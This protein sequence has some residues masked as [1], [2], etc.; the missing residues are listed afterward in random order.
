[1]WLLCVAPKTLR[2]LA[3]AGFV[4]GSVVVLDASNVTPRL[5]A[6]PGELATGGVAIAGS[7][8]FVGADDRLKVF[9]VADP[10][11]PVLMGE[12]ASL[13]ADVRAM[14]ASG[15]VVG[16]VL[17]GGGLRLVDAADPKQPIVVASAPAAD[18]TRGVAM[19]GSFVLLP[20]ASV[21]RILAAAT[22]AS[23]R[24]VAV[25][26]PPGEVL[27]VSVAERIAYVVTSENALRTLDLADPSR[28][29]ELG[30]AYMRGAGY[31]L[32]PAIVDGFA[33]TTLV[34]GRYTAAVAF[35]V[36]DPARVVLRSSIP[37]SL[38]G[39]A[40]FATDR[41]LL[42]AANRSA[43]NGGSI[44]IVAPDNAGGASATGSLRTRWAPVEVAAQAGFAYVLGADRYLRAL[45]ISDPSRPRMVSTVGLTPIGS[46]PTLR[47]DE[48]YFVETGYRVEDEAVWAYF[49]SRGGVDVFGYPVSRAF[50][51]LGCRVQM[52][53]RHV[54]QLCPNHDVALLNLLDSEIFPY[55]T[56]N[57]ASLPAAD[58]AMKAATPKVD[59]PNYA[60]AIIDFVRTQAPDAFEGQPVSFGQTFF[61]S[62]DA[63]L[64]S[65]EIWGAPISRPARDPANAAFVY[66]RFQRGIMHYDA[67]L[68]VTRAMLLADY[69]KGVL[70]GR[71]LPT[72]LA[73][74]ARGSPFFGQYCP[75]AP[76]W[77]CRPDD[78]PGTDLTTAFEPG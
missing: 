47:H 15:T 13:G 64:L 5:A 49:S 35:D 61:S 68:G 36:S 57:A 44:A 12:S 53:Q 40:S 32:D 62:T 39:A 14:S 72:D 23:P 3:A 52:F 74:A 42:V 8:L 33:F 67:S 30:A 31:L 45:D 19:F 1:V 65:L 59:A 11:R 41:G 37:A 4:L 46:A 71:H 69:L 27:G 75:G 9:D 28:P 17:V 73:L 50:A 6:Q 56:I 63:A 24:Q 48:R 58:E 26:D 25:Y 54:A 18:S 43:S 78:M 55:S 20:D 2:V 66:Q 77:L 29:V 7:M 60:S 22:P 38:Y 70:I 76:G 10:A 16:V 51:F 34:F 21:V